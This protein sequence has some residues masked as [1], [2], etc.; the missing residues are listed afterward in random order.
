MGKGRGQGRARTAACLAVAAVA[1]VLAGGSCGLP[2]AYYLAPP[3]A[4]QA[5]PLD[6]HFTITTSASS[7]VEFRG[8]ELYYK[9]YTDAAA[10]AADVN[11]GAGVPGTEALVAAKF[12]SVCRGPALLPASGGAATDASPDSRTLPLIPIAT[13]DRSSSFTILVNV[14]PTLGDT[15][16][17]F[18]YTSPT[19]GEIQQ[20]IDRHASASPGCKAF[21][22]EPGNYQPTDADGGFL[23]AAPSVTQVYI[24]MYSVSYGLLD[25]TPIYSSPVYMGYLLLSGFQP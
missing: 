21:S 15:G 2:D 20:E 19:T 16:S 17:T 1:A 23:A 25:T 11:L 3:N 14:N 13:A 22:F 10:V 4:P 12:L 7:E 5:S 6:Y 18:D 8:Y 24:A 9:V